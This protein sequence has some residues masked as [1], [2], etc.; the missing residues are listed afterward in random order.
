MA[1]VWQRIRRARRLRHLGHFAPVAALIGLA[2]SLQFEARKLKLDIKVNT[3]I[4]AADTRMTQDLNA[5]FA[6]MQEK[7]GKKVR[8]ATL[9][10]EMAK[11]M[12]P[13]QVSAIVAWLTHS[14]CMAEAT[15]HE[16]GSGC[17][18]QLRWARSA[19]LFA[20]KREGVHGAPTPEDVRDGL[21]TLADFE[22]GD[23]PRSGD[24]SMGAPMPFERV[25]RHL[26]DGKARL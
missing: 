25:L 26:R 10:P 11:L 5:A 22:H 8:A 14:S 17:F 13:E 18:T 2:A 15:V 3:I 12:A 23:I 7:K 21:A 20:T 19:P 4:P 1:P 24:G 16:A 9:P 6:K